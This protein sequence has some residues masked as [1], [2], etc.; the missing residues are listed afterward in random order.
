MHKD[1][2]GW[3]KSRLKGEGSEKSFTAWSPDPKRGVVAPF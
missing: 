1:R 2:L 3:L